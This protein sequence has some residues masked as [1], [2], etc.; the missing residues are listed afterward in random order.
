MIMKKIVINLS[1]L[2]QWRHYSE[3]SCWKEIFATTEKPSLLIGS[4]FKTR[5][6]WLQEEIYV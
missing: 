6:P 1:S 3:L 2:G 4:S 5:C